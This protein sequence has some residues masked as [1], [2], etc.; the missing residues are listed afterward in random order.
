MAST[1]TYIREEDLGAHALLDELTWAYERGWQPADVLHVTARSGNLS[2]VPL[3]AA[4]VLFDAHRSRAE[5]RAPEVWLRQ[6]RTVAER[7]PRL[8]ALATGIPPGD[9]GHLFGAALQHALPDVTRFQV[10]GL[11]FTWKYLPRFTPLAPPPSRWPSMR[12]DAGPGTA[13]D[14]RILDRIRGLLSKAESTDFP[15]EAEAL[16][17]K[18]QEL[19]TRYAVSAALLSDYDAPAIRGVRLHLDNPYAK[20]KV[21]L[22]TA[23][24]SANRARTV[25][26]AKIG[27]ATVVGGDAELHQIEVLFGSLLVQATRAMAA[28]GTGGRAGGGATAFRRA[29]LAGYADRIGER[30]REA[31]ARAT[32]DA[33]A[34]AHMPV[35]TLAPILARRSAAVDDEFRR[36]FPATRSTRTRTVDAEGW[37]AGR[38]AAENARLTSPATSGPQ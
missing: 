32:V 18:A 30:L 14:P 22:L 6:I 33:A 3:G 27:I 16:T 29:F 31:D 35:T 24:G 36:L 15:E 13:P 19:V 34:D 25:W 26:F 2:D 12:A 7:H 4:A 38:D 21:L 23:I 5:D 9:R 1:R 10:T 11:A 17:A 37:H 20:E 28:A 8:A